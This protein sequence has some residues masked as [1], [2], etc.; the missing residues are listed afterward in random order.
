[1]SNQKKNRFVIEVGRPLRRS[2]LRYL[3]SREYNILRR[4]FAM[5]ISDHSW[6]ATFSKGSY[7]HEIIRHSSPVLRQL[8]HVDMQLQVNKRTNLHLAAKHIHGLII[9]PGECFS[10]WQRVGRPSA[11]KGYLEGLVLRGGVTSKGVGGGLC[12]MGNLLFWMFLNAGL[13]ILERHRHSFDV[14]PDVNRSMPFGS[15]A[16]LAYNYLD[17]QVRND[18]HY[19]IQII[20][21][22]DDNYLYGRLMADTKP[23]FDFLVRE[24]EHEIRHEKWGGF[25]RHN[26][27]V[28]YRIEKDGSLTP[29]FELFNHALLM[30]QPFLSS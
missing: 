20:L 2:R 27:L 5:L 1:M 25:S 15:G 3:L 21:E 26:R 10:F 4:K 12:Q 7:K 13:T 22:L 14:F 11:R 16:T 24:E 9:H 6:A 28:R 30:Y 29:D 8:K 19:S 18:C 17:L 23:T